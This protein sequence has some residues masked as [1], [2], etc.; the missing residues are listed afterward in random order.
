MK[1]SLILATINRTNEIILFINSLMS[2]KFTNYELI[3]IDQNNDDR[4]KNIYDSYKSKFDIQYYKSDI[5]GL[6][7]N[8]N[9]GLVHVS[10]DI[11]A[12]P[13][14]DCEYCPDTLEKVVSFFTNKPDFDFYT[15][16]TKEKESDFSI[17]SNLKD[18]TIITKF[19][20]MKAGI[21]FTIFV[22]NSS[23]NLFRFDEKLGLGAEFG[24]GEESDLLLFLL[25]NNN[26]GYYFANNYIF[27]PSKQ[28]TPEKMYNY[29]KGYG[30]LHKK[31]VFQYGFYSILFIFIFTLFKNFVKLCISQDKNIRIPMIKGRISGFLHY[32]INKTR[33]NLINA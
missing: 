30:A 15:C 24:S 20:I 4:V 31:A 2:Q 11:V 27:H 16:N 26:K 13:D 6:S 21:S 1:F 23:L 12:F 3:I 5:K 32:R 28:N 7:I 19:N 10:G 18:D 29:G 25:K 8:R 22:R 9:I 33:K 14:D 17:V